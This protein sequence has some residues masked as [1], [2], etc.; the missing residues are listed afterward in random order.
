MTA[1]TVII[2]AGLAGLACATTLHR[3]GRPVRLI[4][5]AD[6]VGGRLRT[7]L[8]DGFRCDRGFPVLIDSYPALDGLVDLPALRARAFDPGALVAVNG[9]FRLLPDC[10]R[11]PGLIFQALFGPGSLGDKLAI[12]RI[13]SHCLRTPVDEL[14]ADR[15]SISAWLDDLGLSDSHLRSAFLDPW[16][17]GIVL[18]RNLGTPAG[19]MQYLFRCFATGSAIL[20]EGGMEAVATQLAAA[21]PEPAITCG[22]PVAAIE[23]GGVRLADGES[24]DADQIVV[25]TEAGTTARLTGEDEPTPGPTVRCL[26]FALPAAELPDSRP[27]LFL[28]HQG[29]I[30]NACFPSVVQPSYAPEGWHLCSVSM[31]DDAD[32]SCC[33]ACEPDTEEAVRNQMANWWGPRVHNWRV[34]ACQEIRR[35]QPANAPMTGPGFRKPRANLWICGDHCLRPSI[36]GALASGKAAARSILS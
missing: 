3:A 29:P 20:P 5:A 30:T 26:Q 33:H 13:R 10:Y 35:A 14:L 27:L 1:P 32:S 28:D 36:D 7:D 31:L 2:G 8:I 15:R 34:L 23:H 24:I 16:F 19:H 17:A 21:L 18:D 9:R 4:E 12:A 6:G 22:R 11:Q 25:A